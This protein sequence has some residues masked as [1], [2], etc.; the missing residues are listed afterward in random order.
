MRDP[1]VLTWEGWMSART[2]T[3][4]TRLSSTPST[5]PSRPQ[6]GTTTARS[7]LDLGVNPSPSSLPAQ[8][9]LISTSRISDFWTLYWWVSHSQYPRRS[10]SLSVSSFLSSSSS[11]SW[12]SQS[13]KLWNGPRGKKNSSKNL[14]RWEL[15]IQ[16]VTDKNNSYFSWKEL[17][18]R[19]VTVTKQESKDDYVRQNQKY[20]NSNFSGRNNTYFPADQKDLEV[21][22]SYCYVHCTYLMEVR[23][24]FVDLDD[25][26]NIWNNLNILHIRKCPTISIS[27]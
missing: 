7:T 19:C 17:E 13:S 24:W 2:G 5:S 1:S 3:V 16:N 25:S 15:N 12:F 8:V 10:V 22:I 14:V 21:S 11:S 20:Q 23:W 27:L 18:E 9:G 6:P 26:E 4:R